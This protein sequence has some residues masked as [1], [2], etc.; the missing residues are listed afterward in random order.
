MNKITKSNMNGLLPFG[1]IKP[2]VKNFALLAILLFISSISFASHF[3]YGLITATRLS[4]TSTTVTYRLNGSE[5]WRLGTATGSSSYVVTG[6]NSGS[7]AMPMTS[8]TDPSGGWTNS[9]GSYVITLNKS[10]TPT[11]I[12]FT[13]CCKIST[14]ANNNDSN[15][16]IYTIINTNASGSSPVSTLPAIINMP[17]GAASA[18]YTIP[19]SDPDPG[20]T[21]TYGVPS[22]TGNLSGQSNPSGF[23]INATTGQITFNTVGKTTGQQYNAMVTV[24][25]NNG[26]QI[27]LDFLINMVGASNPPTFDYSVTPL[28]GAVYNVIA[29]QNIS[30]PVKATDTDAG[31]TVSLSVSGLPA[32]ITTSNFSSNALPATGNPSVTNFSWTPAAAQIGTT[33]ILNI[34]ATDNVGVQTTTSVTLKVVAEPAPVFINPTPIQSSLRQIVSGVAF[35]DVIRASSSLNS[36][37]SIAF[38]TGAPT[39]VSFSPAI[40]TAGTNPG[41][42]T[43]NW[44]PTPAN[45]GIHTFSFQAT[46]AGS[47]TIFA[48]RTYQIIV[49]SL[50]SFSSLPITSVI[51]GQPYSYNVTVSDLDIPYGDIIDIVGATIPSWLTLT[52]TG[53]GTA[54]LSGTP[55]AGDVG[56]NDVEL[57]AEDIH[58]HGNPSHTE[59]SF[60][61]TVIEPAPVA[62]CKNVTI[63]LNNLGTASLNT[64]DIDGGSYSLVGISSMTIS[65]SNFNCSNTGTNLVDLTVFNSYGNSNTCAATVTVE[66]HIA[67][68]I[69]CPANVTEIA[70]PYTCDAVITYNLPNVSDNCNSCA[71]PNSIQGYRY[72]GT[73]GGHTYFLSDASMDWPSANTTAQTT[74]GHLVSVADQA[75]N[76]FLNSIIGGNVYFTGLW[77]NHANPNYSEPFGGWEWSDG[78]PVNYTYW[79]PGEPNDY[80]GGPEDYMEMYGFANGQ[81]NDIFNWTQHQYVVEYDCAG[82]QPVLVSGLPSG[83]AF[84]IGTTTVTYAVT[85]ASANT[86]TCSFDVTVTDNHGPTITAQDIYITLDAESC[87]GIANYN[88][89]LT[90]C[91]PGEYETSFSTPSGSAF[92]IGVTTVYVAAIDPLHNVNNTQF[93]VIVSDVTAPVVTCP[94]NITVNNDPGQCGAVVNFNATATD[95]QNT[96]AFYSIPSGAFFPVGTTTVTTVVKDASNNSAT[97][98]F[99][100][101]VNDNE[102]PVI[103]NCSNDITATTDS[104][105]CGAVVTFQTPVASENCS[106]QSRTFTYTGAQETFTVPSGVT[107]VIV[108]VNGAAGGQGYVYYYGYPNGNPGLGG[109][110]QATL[111]VTP[112]QVL[113]L[114]VGGA[115][116]TAGQYNAGAGGYNGGA[117]GGSY[118]NSYNGGGGGGASDIRTNAATLNDRL[119]V[120][121]GGG[122]SGYYSGGGNGGGLIGADAYGYSSVA[123]GGT[124]TQGGIGGNYYGNAGDG[125]FGFGGYGQDGTQGGGGGAGWY[126]GG[127]GSWGDGAGGSSYTDPSATNVTHIQG[128]QS[129]NGDITISYSQ[130]TSMIQTPGLASGSVF[131]V[132]TTPI[133]FTA[134]DAAGNTSVCSFNVTITDVEN[135]IAV[136]KNITVQLDATGAASIT[137]AD[138]DGGSSDAC[139]IASLTIQ[140]SNF[141]CANVGA[142]TLV[143]LVKDNNGNVSTCNSTVTVEDKIAPVAVC[144]N[145][146]VQLNSVGTASIVAND[147]NGGSTDACGIASL[148]INKST[149]T[150]ANVGANTV[151]LTVTDVNGNVSTCNSTVT[152]QDKIAPVAVCKNIT[153]QLNSTGTVAIVANDVNGGSTDACGIASLT[154]NKS[155]FTCANVG[156]NT[157]TLTVTD[158]N[159]NVSTCNST[160]TVKD[161]ILPT[162]VTKNISKTLV[163]GAAS[164]T[165]A[166]VNNNS[167]DNCSIASMTVSPSNFTCSNIGT[168][169]V[170]LTVTD[171]NGNVNTKTAIVT[172]IGTIPSVNIANSDQPVYCQGGFVVLTANTSEVSTYL[173]SNASVSNT[174][175]VHASGTYSVTITNANGCKAKTSTVVTYSETNVLS[176]YVV[177]GTKE[178]EIEK[179]ST[180][181]SGGVGVTSSKG[182]IEVEDHS[183]ITAASTFAKA[184]KVNVQA[185]SSVTNKFTGSP[186]AITLPT[187][188]NNPSCGDDNFCHRHRHNCRDYNCRERKQVRDVNVKVRKNTN[189]VLADSVYGKI[190]IESGA[191]VLFTNPTIFADNIETASNVTIQFSGCTKIALCNKMEIG[192]YNVFNANNKMVVVYT[193][194]DVEIAKGTVLFGSIYTLSKL[195]STGSATAM[196]NLTGM[197]IAE[198][199]HTHYTNF[200]WSTVCG[201]C[202]FL[203]SNTDLSGNTNEINAESNENN[204]VSVYPNPS[205]GNFNLQVKSVESANVT[206]QVVTTTGQIILQTTTENPTGAVQI[207]FD[208][209]D[210][211]NGIYLLKIQV[212]G[213]LFIKK[214]TVNK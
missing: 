43:L 121:G 176:S 7:F 209:T 89:S 2:F 98:A 168:N 104:A 187:F 50:P 91:T 74:G 94:S 177:I 100:V 99:T 86:S 200:N 108:D 79:A 52:S 8:V 103:S 182:E 116:E 59:Q 49:N 87:E 126:G 77:Q 212:G 16:D 132:G 14:I 55:T 9:S 31:S 155:T 63:Q 37:V 112:G 4:E 184:F 125:G 193:P 139:G 152:V 202:S 136:C 60:S 21:L 25:D 5:A 101:T 197:F 92:P 62:V 44:T 80:N 84:P 154:I 130:T 113:Y 137:A 172:I 171:V 56:S 118:D 19:A 78:T 72:L 164:I 53:N 42:T 142:N 83:S 170:T 163:N 11:K 123:T 186:A 65:Q 148:T 58:H 20:S 147:V 195:E 93:S 1:N 180:V 3:R 143:L 119:V 188:L 32:Y 73:Y 194:E 36:N 30:F 114:N 88:V 179:Y 191:T 105:V 160:V 165:A 28:N 149:F 124:Q 76:D 145:I 27:E 41:Q 159:G 129:G 144:K 96:T 46:I 82:P 48:T 146:T 214:V 151:V 201:S 61:I 111:A 47:P 10:A 167:F 57:E 127:G 190:E 178:V 183:L 18:T 17:I 166:D 64:A 205:D 211:S 207:P 15:W 120:A 70:N 150:C 174:I 102:A 40:P 106:L 39:N 66:D 110:V 69:T 90:D 153:V 35:S 115:G 198:N 109:K 135:P 45:F 161:L 33:N 134:T 169:T 23:S 107:S 204:Y 24:T 22:F 95:C 34:I 97:C 192:E 181:K 38:V 29:G 213:N 206:V 13:S 158:V 173:W 131:P 203:K 133:A 122:A 67:P 6:G 12:E 117:N 189:V 196:N 185:G 81:W 75:E 68:V 156:A 71:A 210:Y 199:V 141:T 128:A 85:D 208:L 54:T 162:V 51:V 26:N 138:V 157:V 140:Q 175:N